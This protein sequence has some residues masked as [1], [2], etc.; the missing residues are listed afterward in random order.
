M[1]ILNV[2]PLSSQ[3]QFPSLQDLTSWQYI[4]KDPQHT[5]VVL[6]GST[7][8]RLD[9][10]G[11]KWMAGLSTRAH[12]PLCPFTIEN[13]NIQ[14][15]IQINFKIQNNFRIQISKISIVH[16]GHHSPSL[17]ARSVTNTWMYKC[18]QCMKYK[19]MLKHIPVSA[20]GTL[21]IYQTLICSLVSKWFLGDIVSTM[22]LISN[23]SLYYQ[24][25]NIQ[26]MCIYGIWISSYPIILQYMGLLNTSVI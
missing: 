16:N 19:S 18:N 22:G 1:F 3:L 21:G 14:F 6:W 17:G 11:C 2:E 26:Y 20:P 8:Q 10:L 23:V 24:Y 5:G 7:K 25:L 15:Q 12:L 4:H 9:G 13:F